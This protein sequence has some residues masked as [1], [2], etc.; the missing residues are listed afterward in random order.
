MKFLTITKMNA[1]P[2]LA[3]RVGAGAAWYGVRDPQFWAAQNALRVYSLDG[4][5]DAYAAS[6]VDP[7]GADETAITDQMIAD[8]ITL[9]TRHDEHESPAS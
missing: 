4:W 1:D 3:A 6:T 9:I 7:P 5:A 2:V 8:A